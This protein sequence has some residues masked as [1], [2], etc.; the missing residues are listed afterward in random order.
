[1][2]LVFI[3]PISSTVAKFIFRTIH[4]PTFRKLSN[5]TVIPYKA[6][7]T[8]DRHLY[9]S[10]HNFLLHYN[11]TLSGVLGGQGLQC[12]LF[13]FILSSYRFPSAWL[14]LV[15]ITS[16][17]FLCSFHWPSLFICILLYFPFFLTK[18]Q[19]NAWNRMALFLFFFFG[20][21]D[22]GR[23]YLLQFSINTTKNLLVI[24]QAYK[25]DFGHTF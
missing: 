22:C 4:K 10:L 14:Y 19:L 25:V 18:Y 9:L 12:Q 8:S 5:A 17:L 24:M 3:R 6:H 20:G 2:C 21:G 15:V 23:I 1:M 7:M 16:F 13:L 11:G